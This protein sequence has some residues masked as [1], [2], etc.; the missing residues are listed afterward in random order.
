MSPRRPTVYR[1][2]YGR[3]TPTV[4]QKSLLFIGL[5][6]EKKLDPPWLSFG[7]TMFLLEFPV[8][9]AFTP[10]K[11]MLFPQTMVYPWNP[12]DFYSIQSGIF[13]WYSQ[14][15]GGVTDSFWKSPLLWINK[16]EI[17]SSY[18][19]VPSTVKDLFFEFF[20]FYYLF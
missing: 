9:I 7:F 8:G 6:Q 5:F 20:Y 2:F 12:N 3:I 17:S 15:G 1:F 10:W 11:S 16:I 4:L 18:R 19:T 14:D 13:H